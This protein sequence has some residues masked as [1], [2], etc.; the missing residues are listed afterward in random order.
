MGVRACGGA[1]TCTQ[2]QSHVQAHGEDVKAKRQPRAF[3]I[4]PAAPARTLKSDFV[5]LERSPPL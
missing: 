3:R 5:S 4:R 1:F 2:S